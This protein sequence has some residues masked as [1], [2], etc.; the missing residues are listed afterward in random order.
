M[1]KW[2]KYCIFTAALFCFLLG[3]I[4]TITIVNAES[5][6]KIRVGFYEMDGFQVY[7]DLRNPVGYNVD[8]LNR[9]SAYT[10]WTY[11]YVKINDFIQ[12]MDMLKTHQIDLLAPAQMTSERL[13]NYDFST[14]S[15]GTEYTVLLTQE[16]N[17]A[18]TYEDYESF[19]G[20]RVGAVKDYLMTDCFNDYMEQNGFRV[21]LE[22]YDSPQEA[23]KA[24][25]Q[26]LVDG[27]VANM[28]MAGDSHKVLAR[29]SS[30]PYYYMTWKGNHN[31][32]EPLD[33]A[34]GNLKNTYPGLEN[35][36]TQTY[37]P[38]YNEQYF[39]GEEEEYIASL[40]VLKVT[41]AQGRLPISF[42]NEETGEL[43]GV[44][45]AIFDRIQEISGL[46]FEYEALPLGTV[47]YDYLRE[48]GF[49]LITGVEYNS[50][51]MNASGIHISNPYLSTKKVMVGQNS[52][53]FDKT[54][55]LTVAISTGS[56]TI[57]DVL[58]AEYPNFQIIDYETIGEC[59]D[60][61][62]RG[63]AD[64]LIQNQYVAE[65]WLTRPKYENL[66][67]IPAEGLDDNLCFSTVQ[68]E[69]GGMGDD[70]R[71]NE[72]LITIINKAL[73]QISQDELNNIIIKETMENKYSYTFADVW[74]RYKYAGTIAA[75]AIISGACVG[76]YI[77]GLKK[78]AILIHQEEENKILLEQ[79]RYQ[80]IMD[81]SEEM[82]YEISLRGEAS[83]ASDRIR[84]KFGW[85]IPERVEHPNVDKLTAIW[86]VYP[87][88]KDMLRESLIRL[89]DENQSCEAII[90]M[91]QAD[92]NYIWCK[93]TCF[94]LL[95]QYNTLVSIVGKIVDVDSEVREKEKLEIESR[96][97]GLTGLLN[98]KTFTEEA[99]EYLDEHSAEATGIIFVDLDYF[100]IVN[101][102][103]GH[104]T[105][106][107]AIQDAARKL[108]EIFLDV[109]LVARFGGDEFCIFVKN[110]S[111]NTLRDKL[112]CAVERL[113]ESYLDGA[114]EVKITASIGAVYCMAEK[115]DYQT[116]L[117]IAD[118][119]VYEAKEKG[120]N[121]FV[122]KEKK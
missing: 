80:L 18:Y 3:S 60:A 72:E 111:H 51:N 109:G 47:D 99:A 121:Q 79:K 59:F 14:Y 33:M 77:I 9:V 68:Y 78:R 115:A 104:T 101:D 52:I 110:I 48:H 71:Y 112:R 55:R 56:K 54:S 7:D 11:E 108:K 93:V 39:S 76:I 41:Y 85:A 116:L 57:K 36:L 2:R 62:K 102:T 46:K 95:D 49:N 92:G 87:D 122:Q 43:D 117:D 10:G 90:R 86:H 40:G 96:T 58:T 29:F 75:I 13:E 50:V 6:A 74:Y 98:K 44:S 24:L 94:P 21:Q 17:E 8:Y 22:Y 97:D 89:I 83:I 34:M 70:V 53:V 15:F 35:E 30:A 37:F 113:Q 4:R 12:G 27:M 66:A 120:R 16:G 64:L 81:K 25:D 105:G 107:L 103:L 1:K 67:V 61:V 20:M 19:Q 31:L 28:M 100:K 82:I 118:H 5:P 69:E 91:Q 32:L 106:D 63:K 84:E 42:T 38:V 114:A 26:G 65:Y 73:S 88:D 45:R 119:A 23:L